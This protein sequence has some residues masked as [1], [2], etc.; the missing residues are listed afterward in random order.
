M[1]GSG[2]EKAGLTLLPVEEVGVRLV[3]VVPA[4]KGVV[5]AGKESFS[6]NALDVAITEAD[7][8]AAP[9]PSFGGT[10]DVGAR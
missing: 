7:V 8:V 1:S 3:V 4:A 5:A 6:R 2:S 10:D 9:V